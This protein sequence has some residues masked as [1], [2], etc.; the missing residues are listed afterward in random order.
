MGK[1]I[2]FEENP[3]K[4]GV[5]RFVA[6]YC[7]RRWFRK[8]KISYTLSVENAFSFLTE[9]TM[10]IVKEK[11]KKDYPD[12]KIYCTCYEEFLTKYET[13]EFWA[14]ARY[15]ANSSYLTN[16]PN[17]Y[18]VRIG[19]NQVEWTED[20]SDAEICLVRNN[21]VETLNV[22]RGVEGVR[23]ALY[24][25][26]LNLINELLTPMMMIVCTSRKGKKE[27]KYFSKIEG[28][29]LRLVTTSY[30]AKKFTYQDVQNAFE[31]LRTH[32]KNFWY[33]ILPQFKDNVHCRDIEYYF[34]RNKLSRSVVVSIKVGKL[35][36]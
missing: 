18:F 9:E 19:K 5:M 4:H 11:I 25:V 1:I 30:A 36:G 28:N 17:G 10:E 31:Y 16:E 7:E 32:N 20:I 13:H 27:T 34:E 12:A 22:I 3:K 35:N 21:M 2:Y 26:Y 6:T 23:A 14:I 33:A 24:P 8:E 29:R 15:G